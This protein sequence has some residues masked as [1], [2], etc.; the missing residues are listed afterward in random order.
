MKKME[1]MEKMEKM[2]EKKKQ[3]KK[4]K[5][6]LM[7]GFLETPE[8]VEFQKR[9][10]EAI[11][12]GGTGLERQTR[13]SGKKKGSSTPTKNK[14][15]KSDEEDEEKLKSPKKRKASGLAK[16]KALSPALSAFLG[17]SYLPRTEV[18]KRL[19]AYIK[20]NNLQS[21]KDRRKI[22]F[23]QRLKDV[24]KCKTTDYFKINRLISNHVIQDE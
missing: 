22:V 7:E 12:S 13:S 24:F 20:E 10:Y 18:V 5:P 19:H 4:E 21:P 3:K 14:K 6:E 1:K 2:K 17:E 23:D 9:L 16:P 8:D 11:K 15:Q